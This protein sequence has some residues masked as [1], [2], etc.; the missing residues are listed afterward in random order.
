MVELMT[1]YW[2]SLLERL[3]SDFTDTTPLPP[4]ESLKRKILVKVKYTPPEQVKTGESGSNL[5]ARKNSDPDT[6]SADEAADAVKKGKIIKSL[7]DMGIYTRAFHF[8]DFDQ[9]E[10]RIPT[11]VFSLGESKLLKA[12]EEQPQKVLD[13][14]LHYLMRAYPKGTRLRSSN[15]D[16]AP[17]WRFGKRYTLLSSVNANRVE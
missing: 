13:H 14:N 2:G 12:C 16:P 10:A 8:K 3:P 11:H 9:P 1:D 7:S 4:L 15:L 6:S 17:F 5:M